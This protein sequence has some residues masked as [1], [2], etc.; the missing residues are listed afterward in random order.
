MRTT[1]SGAFGLL[2]LVLA[3]PI[4]ARAGASFDFLFSANSVT[5]DSQL[6]LNLT[7]GDYGYPRKVIEPVLPRLVNVEEDLPVVLFLA[8]ASGRP[9]DFIVQLRSQRLSW[10]VIF[11]CVDV[12]YD[13]LFVGI[14]RDPGPP[15][16]KAWGHWKKNPKKLRLSDDE[17]AGLAAVQTGHRIAG[18]STFD[19]ARARGE[20]K[21]VAIVVADKK[22]RPHSPGSSKKDHAAPGKAKKN[23]KG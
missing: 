17:I 18:L 1:S 14:D 23:G 19:I 11:T 7:V 22:G 5:N 12:P 6:F 3:C 8:H 15:Y 21:S 10:S 2:L 4:Q 9:V 13:V 16:G 20:G